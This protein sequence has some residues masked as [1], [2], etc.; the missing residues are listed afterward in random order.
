[1]NRDLLLGLLMLAVAAVFV[2]YGQLLVRRGWD[3]LQSHSSP[4]SVAAPVQPNPE[5]PPAPPRAAGPEAAAPAPSRGPTPSETRFPSHLARGWTLH[6]KGDSWTIYF[7]LDTSEIPG[8][9]AQKVQRGDVPLEEL[10]PA[11]LPGA[12]GLYAEVSRQ[13]PRPESPGTPIGPV[14]AD[15]VEHISY[16]RDAAGSGRPGSMNW[17]Y[18]W[19]REGTAIKSLPPQAVDVAGLSAGS[20]RAISGFDRLATETANRW[21]TEA[22]QKVTKP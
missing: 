15:L 19:M 3:T 9:L 16:V 21:Y 14:P 5:S 8:Y 17:N 20:R 11:L 18:E 12:R 22:I 13:F 10:A 1:M 7:I 6:K 2:G 4:T